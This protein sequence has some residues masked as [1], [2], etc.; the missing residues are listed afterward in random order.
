[1]GKVSIY[2]KDEIGHKEVHHL[3]IFPEWR[4]D[5]LIF[6]NQCVMSVYSFFTIELISLDFENLNIL[7]L[8]AGELSRLVRPHSLQ[9]CN[10][11]SR[12]IAEKLLMRLKT[13]IV[14]VYI[15]EKNNFLYIAR[16]N[17]E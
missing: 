9:P 16:M 1:M 4:F 11:D 5:P 13:N 14:K 2:L 6:K 7:R 12:R 17:E 8:R 10:G 15:Y 3:N